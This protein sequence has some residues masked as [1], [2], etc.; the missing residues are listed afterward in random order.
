[1]VRF[2]FI[3]IFILQ[4]LLAD[5]TAQ[6]GEVIT[7]N[8]STYQLHSLL[9]EREP[10]F[11]VL[12]GRL[13][14]ST[15]SALWRNYIGFWKIQNDSLF[16]DSV[17]TIINGEFTPVK[18]DDIY[19]QYKTSNGYFASWVN[20]PL[21]VCYGNIIHYV[22]MGWQSVFENNDT[23]NVRNGIAK[24]TESKKARILFE[25]IS[26]GQYH[27]IM[28]KFPY[29]QFPFIT[30]RVT[31]TGSYDKFN[32]DNIPIHFNVEILDGPQLNEEQTS[33][34]KAKISEFIVANK[35]IPCYMM[36]EQC[37]T[38][39]YTQSFPFNKHNKTTK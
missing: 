19:G 13:P 10:N 27:K 25:K 4:F 39:Q 22:H 2:V 32:I 24:L 17:C 23:Y 6:Y 8:D 3:L 7:I 26:D 29:H 20:I 14:K 9:L 36:G 18:I 33:A 30:Q 16:L 34:L 31:V 15:S 35:L 11:K 38:S 37:V 1:M 12:E 5:A 21:T 28:E